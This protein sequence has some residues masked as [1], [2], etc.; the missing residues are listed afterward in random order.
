MT[1][2]ERIY[3]L[4]RAASP[5]LSFAVGLFGAV[6][7]QVRYSQFAWVLIPLFLLACRL[8]LK[9]KVEGLAA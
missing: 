2:R 8:F 4:G 1:L 5:G 7:G 9:P 6:S 3:R